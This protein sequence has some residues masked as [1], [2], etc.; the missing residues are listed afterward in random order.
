[1]TRPAAAWRCSWRCGCGTRGAPA[2]GAGPRLAGH[3]PDAGAQQRLP[4]RRHR[5]PAGVGTLTASRSFVGAADAASL[6]PLFARPDRFAPGAGCRS[7]ACRAAPCRGRAARRRLRGGRGRGRSRGARPAVARR[8]PVAHLLPEAADAVAELGRWL[9]E[10]L[11]DTDEPDAR[12]PDHGGSV[13]SAAR[14]STPTSSSW[15]AASAAAS[16]RCGW[17][18]RATGSPCSRPA[19]GSPTTTAAHLVGPAPLPLGAAARLLRHPA[20]PPAARRPGASPAP[21]SAAAR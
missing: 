17:P 9:A 13:T 21:A 10:R 11:A 6:S 3:R 7:P 20:D 1:M 16:P 5:R 18:R 8:P 2:A 4:G 14:S 12:R 19:A 15:A